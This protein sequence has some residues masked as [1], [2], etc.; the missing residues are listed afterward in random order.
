LAKYV[1]FK[2]SLREGK[3]DDAI[4]KLS[5][6]IPIFEQ[7][8]D[9]D[10]FYQEDIVRKLNSDM[11]LLRLSRKEY[12]KAFEI[13]LNG[14]YWEDIAYLAEKVL[15]SQELEDFLKTNVNN[16]VLVRRKQE[17]DGGYIAEKIKLPDHPEDADWATD[18]L[19]PQGP[20][21]ME[22]LRYLLARRYAREG[23]WDKASEYMPMHQNINKT[24][25][26][27]SNQGDFLEYSEV[28]EDFNPKA[29]LQEL[30][31][32]IE[33]AKNV[34][35]SNTERAQNYFNAGIIVRKYGMELIGTELDPDGFVFNGS[36][37]YTDTLE[38]R[39]GILTDEAREGY[40]SWYKD[41]IVKFDKL[42]EKIKKDRNFLY[43]S[44]DEEK[45]TLGSLPAPNMRFHYRYKAADFLWK[46]A[47]LLPDNND[48]KAKALCYGGRILK[49]LDPKKAD[50]FYKQLV[51]TCS[52]TKLGQE[53]NK[54]R[55]FPKMDDF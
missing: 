18:Y 15:T 2:V 47:E 7:S 6:L 5:N 52:A 12:I 33:K 3:V 24:I 19:K 38:E 16:S 8:P 10:M 53:A 13:A 27:K 50:R 44:E 40:K 46:A 54:L 39:F 48:L 23:D 31:I 42:R 49:N 26:K 37:S 28:S 35:I 17:Y 34:A 43:G 22:S 1:D 11:A 36:Y 25:A 4:T 21:L 29:K 45:R 20:T 32:L 9:R 55:W 30:R 14:K 51:R 41:G